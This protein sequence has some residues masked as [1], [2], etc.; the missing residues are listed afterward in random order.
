MGTELVQYYLVLSVTCPLTVCSPAAYRWVSQ[1][2]FVRPLGVPRS[3]SRRT[4]L[5]YR[6]D[7]V[8]MRPVLHVIAIHLEALQKD[9]V[10]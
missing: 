6:L 3:C 7:L 2:S 9:A 5:L 4:V 10:S 8:L 1:L